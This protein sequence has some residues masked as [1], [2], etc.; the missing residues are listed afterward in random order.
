MPQS[1][2][3]TVE[4][5]HAFW[6]N[7]CEGKNNP[8]DYA[9]DDPILSKMLTMLAKKHVGKEA[10]YLEI[11]CNAGRNLKYLHG[12]GYS[13][14][15]GIEINTH[16]LDVLRLKFPELAYVPIANTSLEQ[17]VR[18]IEPESFDCVYSVA[19]LMHI[20]PDSEDAIR[21]L[22]DIT[23]RWIVTIE[24]EESNTWRHFP[25]NYKEFFE[26]CG[27]KQVDYFPREKKAGLEYNHAYYVN[28]TARVF[29]KER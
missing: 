29:E 21:K 10:S 12:A 2:K 8:E 15:A 17:A 20:H 24:D 27:M 7:P 3:P 26:S 23:R 19:V 18:D 13:K 25:R 22:A 16:A 1:Y 11:G 5:C 14:L 4:D 9:D 6:V 28:M